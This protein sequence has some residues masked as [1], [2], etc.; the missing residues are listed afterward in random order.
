MARCAT[1]WLPA[2]PRRVT[3]RRKATGGSF[4]TWVEF[5]AKDFAFTTSEPSYFRSSDLSERGFCGHCGCQLTFRDVGDLGGFDQDIWVAL[6]GLD[7]AGDIVPTH[8]IFT[9]YQLPGFDLDD[10]LPRWPE[11]PPGFSWTASCPTH[12]ARRQ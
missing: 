4:I 10:G 9:D 3:H 11:Q 2:T 5:P 7:R 12:G 1:A 8:H 6:G